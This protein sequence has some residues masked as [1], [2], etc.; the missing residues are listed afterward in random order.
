MISAV[1]LL[2]RLLKAGPYA[3]VAER[4]Y[5]E[6]RALYF[7]SLTF[8]L[9]AIYIGYEATTALVERNAPESS[10]I[11]LTLSVLSLLIMPALAYLKQRTG[12]EMGSKALEADAVETWVCAYLSLALLAG[13]GLSFLLGWWWPMRWAC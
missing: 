1:A 5:A 8:L 10:V 3:S 13:I 7:V 12:R 2:W 6:R 11:G 9:L 4:G